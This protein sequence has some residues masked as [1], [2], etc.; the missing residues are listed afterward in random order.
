LKATPM[1]GR[2]L[3]IQFSLTKPAQT[4]VEILTLTGRKVAVLENGQN[5][6]AGQHQVIWQG[7]STN[8]EVLPAS[9]YLIRVVAQDE[10]GRQVQATTVARLR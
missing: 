8:G 4:Q 7:R 3:A 2:N 6:S 10:E 9:A 1:R 5:R